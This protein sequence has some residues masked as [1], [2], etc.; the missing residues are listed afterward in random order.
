MPL[1]VTQRF[2]TG[3]GMHERRFFLPNDR[4]TIVFAPAVLEHMYQHAQVR[5]YQKEA[6]G[7]LFSA[8][9]HEAEV[10]VT[11]A[12]GPYPEDRRSRHAFE[13]DRRR[14]TA[15]AHQQF[16]I[17]RHVIGLWHT[18]P[19]PLPS[20]SFQD[21]ETAVEFLRFN[22]ADLTGFLLVTLGNQGIP[23]HMSVY[24]ADSLSPMNWLELEEVS[25]RR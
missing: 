19:E 16:A 21:R 11:L 12:T 3:P 1:T 10:L 14:A 7:Q 2:G 25:V 6:G 20:P 5:F 23:L 15:D 18:H 8:N 13:A 17:G 24:L 4:G 22:C 9:P